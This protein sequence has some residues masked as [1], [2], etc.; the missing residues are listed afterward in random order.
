MGVVTI[1]ENTARPL[2]KPHSNKSC[3][4]TKCEAVLLQAYSINMQTMQA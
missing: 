4:K 1:G 2:N 3:N